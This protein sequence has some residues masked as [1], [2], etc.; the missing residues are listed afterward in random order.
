VSDTSAPDHAL[1]IRW[2]RDNALVLVGDLFTENRRLRAL[3]REVCAAAH[4]AVAT[5]WGQERWGLI[6]DAV[7]R[8]EALLG[9]SEG[10]D[11]S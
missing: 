7:S 2:Q 1:A 9:E 8:A 11:K 6:S 4:A 10:E 3:L 5:P